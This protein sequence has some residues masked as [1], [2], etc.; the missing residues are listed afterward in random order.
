[1][2]KVRNIKDVAEYQLC[3][4][5]GACA[6]I[7]PDEIR[8][9]DAVD[10]GRRPYFAQGEPRDPRSAE[11][12]KVCPGIELSHTFD[13]KDPALIRELLDA[14]GPIRE[15]WEGYA[16]DPEIRFVGSSGGVATA[17]ALYC[18]EHAGFYGVLHTRARPDAPYLNHTVM[19]RTREELLAGAGSRY[20][21][22]SPCDGLKM[23]ED[24]P[25]PCVFIGKP[26]DVAAVEK[27]RRVRPALD[28][29]IGLTIAFFCAGTPSTRGTLEM[30]KRMGVD[31]PAKVTSLRYRGHGWPGRATVSFR[32]DDGIETRDLTYEQSWGE[33]LQKYRQWRCYICP[34]HSGEF[35]DVAV[36]DA[37]HRKGCDGG[38]GQSI[39]LGRTDEGHRLIQ[40]AAQTGC[41]NVERVP[42]DVVPL[43]Q[44]G[45][46]LVRGALWGRILAMRLLAIPTPRI[47]GM[48]LFRLWWRLL[49]LRQKAQSFYGT[50]KRVYVKALARR[51]LIT[52]IEESAIFA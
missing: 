11:A 36:G 4:G 43:S 28:A 19:S 14:W 12:M 32:T 42:A 9:V 41:L 21:P 45:F 48:P 20:A 16:A 37:W 33:V 23:I 2:P 17:L 38:L 25:G 52:H 3:C 13:R 39:V 40:A 31:D 8:M 6:Y 29:K 46:P 5:C 47:S 34:D 22:A 24:A 51:H 49:S 30:L 35:A 18:L 10:Y 44:P 7:S 50:T 26:C 1:M 15:V 27:A